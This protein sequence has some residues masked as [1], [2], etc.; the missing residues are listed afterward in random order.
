MAKKP[1]KTPSADGEDAEG[2][3][4][5]GGKKKIIII[6]AAVLLLAGGGGGYFMMKK[7]GGDD[8]AAVEVKKPLVFLD[9]REMTINLANDPGQEKPRVAKV[10]V[11]LELK[12]AKVENE[13]KPLMPRIEDTFQVYMREL[14]A[15]DLAGSAG[16]YRLR[17]EL[18]RRVNVAIH[19]ARAEAVLFKDVIVQ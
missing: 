19:P 6:G 1:T 2:E 11:S 18:L 14:R 10:K 3:A 12:D 9:V 15:S 17:E 13:V 16:L 8:H 5:K 7:K 4:P